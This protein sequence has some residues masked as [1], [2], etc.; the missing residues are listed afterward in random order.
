MDIMSKFKQL[1]QSE[2]NSYEK[3]LN[4]RQEKIIESNLVS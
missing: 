4:L 3:Q 1:M 2:V